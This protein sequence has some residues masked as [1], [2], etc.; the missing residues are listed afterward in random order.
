MQLPEPTYKI[1][2]KGERKETD[3]SKAGF[4]TIAEIGKERIRR[5]GEK[6]LN[7]KK[8]EL[9]N[10]KKSIEGK[11]LQEEAEEKIKQLEETIERLDIGFKVFKLDSSNILA[12]DGSADNLEENLLSAVEN[13]KPD[14]KEED[15]LYEILIKYGIDLAQPIEERTI[16][17]CKV[18]SVGLG[19]LFVC[20]S[21]KIKTDVA[22]GIGNW[23]KELEPE[24]SRVVFKDSGFAGDV[25]K[26]NTIQILKR[27]GI[28]DVKSI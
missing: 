3:A 16:A 10:L 12:W 4:K 13:I 20:L 9:A 2:D 15:V 25:E 14:R 11:M 5:A 27:Y 18:F 7:E 24:V 8:E 21:D 26:T 22:D 1:N 28:T 23:K 19:V 17:G 6:I